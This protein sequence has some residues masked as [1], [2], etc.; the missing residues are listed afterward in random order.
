MKK[1]ITFVHKIMYNYIKEKSVRTV[2]FKKHTAD[3]RYTER[4]SIYE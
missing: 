2:Y 3:L 1:L 4:G